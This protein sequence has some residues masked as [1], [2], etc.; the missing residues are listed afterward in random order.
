MNK[1]LTEIKK[2][3]IEYLLKYDEQPNIVFIDVDIYMQIK[4]SSEFSD[5]KVFGLRVMTTDQEQDFIHVSR[6][7]S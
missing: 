3:A 4:A 2:K 6:V 5:Q 7:D 1:H